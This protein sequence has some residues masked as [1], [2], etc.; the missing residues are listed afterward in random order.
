MPVLP[1]V[2]QAKV[3]A[4]VDPFVRTQNLERSLASITA[5]LPSLATA[6]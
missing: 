5:R 3:A 4:F 2:L 1:N 6:S